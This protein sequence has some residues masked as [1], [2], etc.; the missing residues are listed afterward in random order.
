MKH[1]HIE[2]NGKLLGWYS[3]EIHGIENIPAQSIEIE[4]AQWQIAIDN[5]HNKV[6][7]DGSTELFDF[8][9]PEDAARHRVSEIDARLKQIDFES[10]R[11]LL[12]TST[13]V[14]TQF[15]TDKLL[16]LSTEAAAL[17]VERS[18]IYVAP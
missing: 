2:T 3:T 13:G 15:D 16:S 8:T 17:R 10:I 6:N 12:A 7:A 5:G 18:S 4:D 9:T 14:Q 11:P 1:A